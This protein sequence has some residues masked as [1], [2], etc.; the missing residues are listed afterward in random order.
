[1]F[2]TGSVGLAE[3]QLFFT[4]EPLH[5]TRTKT[6]S[7]WGVGGRGVGSGGAPNNDQISLLPL[8]AYLGADI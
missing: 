4:P 6:F 3:T 5:R 2:E 8:R 1:M 7:L